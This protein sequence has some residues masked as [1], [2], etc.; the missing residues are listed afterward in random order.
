[1][2]P[3]LGEGSH[4]GVGECLAEA[5]VQPDTH[6]D[7]DPVTASVKKSSISSRVAACLRH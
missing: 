3:V 5:V 6:V 2:E 7:E 4:G 1:M